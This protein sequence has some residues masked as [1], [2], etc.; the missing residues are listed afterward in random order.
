MVRFLIRRAFYMIAVM[1]GISVI[2]FGLSRLTGDP[3]LLYMTQGTRWSQEVW[4]A[5]GR[6][7]GLDKPMVIQYLVWAGNAVQRRFRT[8]A[9]AQTELSQNHHRE[10]SRHHP[11][12]RHLVFE[13][14][15]FL[16]LR[17]AP[18]RR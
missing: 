11:T 2:V 5:R 3:R 4:D 15:L 1:I 17:W 16:A 18:Y 10:G 6:E 14:P 13:W 9:V 12:L 7:L 8:V